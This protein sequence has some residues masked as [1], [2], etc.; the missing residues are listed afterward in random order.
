MKV[1]VDSGDGAVS[2]KLTPRST[3]ERKA[4]GNRKGCTWLEFASQKKKV[5]MGVPTGGSL[6]WATDERGSPEG[7]GDE[8]DTTI[9][10]L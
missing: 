8:N 2:V 10:Y 1:N 5:Y 9:L 7:G 4:H 3:K 6:V